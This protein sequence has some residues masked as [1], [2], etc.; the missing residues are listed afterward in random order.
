MLAIVFLA[1]CTSKGPEYFEDE[2]VS[3]PKRSDFRF[4]KMD[5]PKIGKCI[6]ITQKDSTIEQFVIG[7]ALADSS[8]SM[9]LIARFTAENSAGY[10]VLKEYAF[11]KFGAY[12]SRTK[13]YALGNP[14][15][16]HKK[17]LVTHHIMGTGKILTVLSISAFDA[18]DPDFWDGLREWSA[19]WRIK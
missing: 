5:Y 3:I 13:F 12:P 17:N 9:D 19:D 4:E 14:E 6:H 15:K 1:G 18:P 2:F 7:F 8:L 10:E 11:D 16:N